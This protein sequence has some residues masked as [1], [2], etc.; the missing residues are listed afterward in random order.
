MN[1]EEG[2]YAQTQAEK[3]LPGCT[4]YHQF[5]Q[6][7]TSGATNS[8]SSGAGRTQRRMHRSPRV[9]SLTEGIDLHRAM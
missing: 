5:T 9:G 8:D 6:M 4:A 1:D 3:V 2:M 7:N